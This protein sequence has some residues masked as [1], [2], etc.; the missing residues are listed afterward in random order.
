VAQQLEEIFHEPFL[1]TSQLSSH[2]L[3][4]MALLLKVIGN[5]PP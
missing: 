5:I 2:I 3:F 1:W 4:P